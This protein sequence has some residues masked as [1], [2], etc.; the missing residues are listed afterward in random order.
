M[1]FFFI[2]NFVL[3]SAFLYIFIKKFYIF[4]FFLYF[5]SIYCNFFFFWFF[6]FM[7]F[8]CIFILFLLLKK[9][10]NVIKFKLLFFFYI[11]LFF[12]IVLLFLLEDLLLFIF[13]F[14]SIIFF[15][16]FLNLNFIFNNRFILGLFYLIFFSALSGIF[17]FFI[18][19]IIFL[20][21]NFLNFFFFKYFSTHTQQSLLLNVWFFSFIIFS[22]KIPIFP[23]F[24]WLLNLH[25]EVSSENSVY[26]AAIVLK[27]GFVGILKFNFLLFSTISL[28]YSNFLNLFILNGLY[29]LVFTLV[30]ALD[31]KKILGIWSVL[32]INITLLLMWFDQSLFILLFIFSNLSHILSSSSFFIFLGFYYEKYNNK[33]VLFL[34]SFFGTNIMQ[35]FFI[36]LILN[37]LDFPFFLMFYLELFTFLAFSFISFYLFIFLCFINFILFVSSL[38]FYFVVNFYLNKWDNTFLRLD[39]TINDILLIVYLLGYVFCLYWEIHLIFA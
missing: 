7:Y 14:E 17:C 33:N 1:F 18:F 2:F 32:H 24:F 13:F 11:V 38:L 20:N 31:Y 5:F 3:K 19:S 34:S 10:F 37:N 6:F 29:Y 4:Y 26:L 30:L 15:L 23:F 27:S 21:W 36:F 28:F 22:I 12:L 9:N 39:L 25:V 35:F 8:I 16:L